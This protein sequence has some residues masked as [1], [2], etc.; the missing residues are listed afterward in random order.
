MQ[1]E[2]V[3]PTCGTF[4]GELPAPCASLA[5]PYIPV[6][7]RSPERYESAEALGNGTLFPGLNLPFKEAVKSRMPKISNE[8]AELMALDFAV[9]ELGLYLTTHAEDKEALEL[10]WNYIRLSREGREKYR[11]RYGP[12]MQTDITEGEYR[13]LKDP[14]PWEAEGSVK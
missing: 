10:Y 1:S 5:Y 7:G 3:K 12:L 4:D 9:D 13:W 6:Q 2:I 11:K 14:W 8:A